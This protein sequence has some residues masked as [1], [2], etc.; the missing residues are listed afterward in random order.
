MATAE[1]RER[2]RMGTETKKKKK[3]KEEE[4]EKGAVQSK[5]R[6]KLSKRLRIDGGLL[7]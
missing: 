5:R 6:P 4:G 2:R 7:C 1:E 3:K